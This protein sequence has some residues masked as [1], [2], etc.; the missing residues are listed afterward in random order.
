MKECCP[1]LAKEG[2]LL[3]YTPPRVHDMDGEGEGSLFLFTF[4]MQAAHG[5]V[6]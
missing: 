6:P 1:W 2:M 5:H 4:M 3:G